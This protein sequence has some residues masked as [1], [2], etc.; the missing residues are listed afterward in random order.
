MK[1]REAKLTVIDGVA[2]L[3]APCP[4][5]WRDAPA[6]GSLIRAGSSLGALEVLGAVV[7]LRAPAGA[8]GVVT[9]LPGGKRV[10]RRPVG[11]GTHL[12]ALDPEGIAGAALAEEDEASDESQGPV[13]RTP[14]GG[15]FY[16]RPS[17][18]DPPFVQAGD[19]LEGGET[20]ALIEVMKTFNRVRYAG[21]PARVASVG[22]A[23]GD[24]I[25]VGDVLLVFE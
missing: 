2:T 14:L 18:D 4:G 9:D 22:P 15:R 24:D 8:F 12:M 10:G 16:A 17:P 21:D 13:F 19:E 23:D 25:E 6:P 20:V 1:E 7:P 11:H 3:V 5:L